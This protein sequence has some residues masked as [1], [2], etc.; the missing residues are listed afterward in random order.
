MMKKLRVALASALLVFMLA[1]CSFPTL[2]T[3]ETV[4]N[5]EN[6]IATAVA[7]TQAAS[8]VQAAP[9][10]RIRVAYTAGDGSLRL[11]TPDGGMRQLTNAGDIQYVTISPDGS[12]IAFVRARDYQNYSIWVIHADGTNERQLVSSDDFRAMAVAQD[13]LGSA[14]VQLEW[15][16]GTHTL[17]FNT[18]PYFEGPGFFPHDDLYLLDSDSGELTR[19]FEIGR[20]GMFA[21]SPDGS[22]LAL[23]TFQSVSLMNA[24]GSN[25]RDDVLVYEPVMT[26]SEFLFYVTPKWSPDGSFLRVIV[27]PGD[28]L[29]EPPLQTAVWHIPGDGSSPTQIAS[30]DIAF[31]AVA[32]LSPDLN[33]M[34]YITPVSAATPT[35]HIASADGSQNIPYASD[36]RTV[37]SW[38]PDGSYFLFTA[39]ERS[40][41]F[42]GQEGQD[43]APLTE[44]D[45][46]MSVRW[47][48]PQHFIFVHPGDAGFEMRIG[49]VRGQS[50]AIDTLQSDRETW[51]PV[52]DVFP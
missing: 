21:Y 29:S 10:G 20:G 39:G 27:P 14:P 7:A 42:L 43:P 24:D 19:L 13:A 49:Q 4:V 26:Y 47:I 2:T 25:R 51:F 6:E 30:L 23:A 34:M 31:L 50:V 36:A 5:V 3:P 41:M 40:Q 37:E 12:R 46:V 44:F 38:S 16:P 28:P 32:R 17:A 22:R 15:V 48:D 18:Y 45:A 52:F 9:A 35:L 1:A 8:G 11:W 33:R